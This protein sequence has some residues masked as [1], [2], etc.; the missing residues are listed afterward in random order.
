MWIPSSLPKF[1]LLP[2][3]PSLVSTDQVGFVPGRKARDNTIKAIN[4]HSWLTSSK[5]TGFFLS[6][7]AEKVF[8]RVAWDYMTTALRSFGLGDNMLNMI[9]ALYSG[10]TAQVKVNG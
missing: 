1:G 7:D 5:Q 6:L 4:L 10:P 8:D 2:L 3:I 9:L